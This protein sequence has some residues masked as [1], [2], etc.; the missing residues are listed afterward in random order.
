MSPL[1]AFKQSHIAYKALYFA[2]FKLPFLPPWSNGID[3]FVYKF[4][5]QNPNMNF[6]ISLILHYTL[7]HYIQKFLDLKQT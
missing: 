6:A 1:F 7:Q 4:F 5:L 2:T 3:V